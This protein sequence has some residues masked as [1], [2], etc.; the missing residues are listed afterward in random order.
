VVVHPADWKQSIEDQVESLPYREK[1]LLQPGGDTRQDSVLRGLKVVPKGTK[2]VLVHDAARPFV[3]ESLITQ[4]IEGT[5]RH[6]AC[7]PVLPVSDTLKVVQEGRVLETVERGGIVLAQTPQGFDLELLCRA[8]E[9]ARLDR[10]HA[11]DEASLVE[12]LDVAVNTVPGERSNVKV[13][14][15]EDLQE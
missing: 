4:V 14:W 2:M 10:F 6:N 11:T 9:Q 7:I 1:I 3:T 8:F 5:K 13:T 15:P 12:R